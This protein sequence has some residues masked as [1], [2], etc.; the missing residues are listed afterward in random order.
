MSLHQV[1]QNLSTQKEISELEAYGMPHSQL[2]RKIESTHP[3]WVFS[4]TIEELSK[5]TGCQSGS[6][7]QQAINRLLVCY[8]TGSESNQSGLL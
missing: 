7:I 1:A 6:P 8:F 3:D 5:L 4:E 2:M